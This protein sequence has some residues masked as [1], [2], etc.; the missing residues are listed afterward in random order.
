MKNNKGFTLVEMMLV[1]LVSAIVMFTTTAAAMNIVNLERASKET[2][3]TQMDARM[4]SSWLEEL[5]KDNSIKRVEVKGPNNY[6]TELIGQDEQPIIVYLSSEQM[7]VNASGD[8]ILDRV[9]SFDASVDITSTGKSLLN[10]TMTLTPA[11]GVYDQAQTYTMSAFNRSGVIVQ[12]DE[13][14]PTN[15]E[16]QAKISETFHIETPPVESQE[17][18]EQNRAKFLILLLTQIGSDG[19]ITFNGQNSITYAE[20]YARGA[21]GWGTDTPWCA[22]FLSWAAEFV[23]TLGRDG[24]SDRVF[25]ETPPIFANCQDGL[26]KFESRGLLKGRSSTPEIGDYVFFDFNRSTLGSDHVGVVVDVDVENGTFMTIEGNSDNE[27][28]VRQYRLND[29]DIMGYGSVQWNGIASAN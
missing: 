20:W 27:V 9:S 19:K 5:T 21:D 28:R 15:D 4:L 7:I 12:N 24:L 16:T 17:I 29:T 18:K 25:A 26:E 8:V 3:S 6:V 10:V 11:G 1:I 2:A 14:M 13:I 23:D 22:C